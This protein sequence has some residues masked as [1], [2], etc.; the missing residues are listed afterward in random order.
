MLRF[1]KLSNLGHNFFRSFDK[2]GLQSTENVLVRNQRKPVFLIM[3][4]ASFVVSGSFPI[5]ITGRF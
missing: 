5:K 2:H 1:L 3:I 4:S